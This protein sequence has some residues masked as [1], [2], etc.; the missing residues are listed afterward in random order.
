M[1]RGLHTMV[2]MSGTRRSERLGLLVLTTACALAGCAPAGD[3]ES[4]GPDEQVV[5]W[6]EEDGADAAP[7]L[8]AQDYAGGSIRSEV[9][10][11]FEHH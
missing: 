1:A 10:L 11:R 7:D 9:R 2:C 3:L 6:L 8:V 4:T 5:E